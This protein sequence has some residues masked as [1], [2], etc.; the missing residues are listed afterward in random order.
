METL[1]VKLENKH[2]PTVGLPATD[3]E[4]VDLSSLKGLTVL[5]AYPRTS[6]PD[7]PPIEGWDQIPGARGCTPQ[8][9][10]FA[11]HYRE[12][13]AAGANRVFGLST[14]DTPYQF[15]MKSRLGLPFEVLSD[16]DLKFASGLDLPVFEAGGMRLLKRLTLVIEDGTIRQVFYPVDDPAGN[17]LDVL[18]WLQSKA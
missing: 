10:G 8:C 1:K 4:I 3:G 15:E 9:K 16:A 13:L 18:T 12:I 5:Y 6:P 11:S 14:Q 17:A 2:V 7:S